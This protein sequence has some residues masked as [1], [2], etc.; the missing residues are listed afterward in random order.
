MPAAS[1]RVGS[2]WVGRRRCARTRAASSSNANGLT[3]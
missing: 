2:D 3:T 1:R